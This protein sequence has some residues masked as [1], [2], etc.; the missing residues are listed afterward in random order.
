MVPATGEAEQ[1]VIKFSHV[2]AE[3]TPKGKA[4][5]R[6]KE[7]VEQKL[8]GLARVEV[9]PNAMLM[10]DE[11]V[12]DGLLLNN[13]QFAAPS[14][15]QLEAY[16]KA[17]QIFDLPFLFDSILSVDRFQKSVIGRKLLGAMQGN[18]IEGLCFMHN[19]MKQLSADAPLRLP[20]DA[21]GKKFRI[22]SS[23]VLQ[24]QFEA[25]GAVPVRAPFTKVFHLLQTH[26][27]DG[28][29]NTWSNIYSQKFYQVQPYITESNHGSL[30]YLFIVAKDFWGRL[31]ES[32]RS[33]L[34][35]AANDSARTATPS[36]ST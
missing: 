4:A 12:V 14:L 32:V 13:V 11:N 8:S 15:S 28:Q 36:P 24:A 16:S 34:S 3:N 9:Y 1:F 19:G 18:G 5:L 22:Q 23:S 6:F 27:V 21:K 17:Y 33:V 2:V 31:P 10:D 30:E 35:R 25:I 20:E 29:E 26:T 7:L